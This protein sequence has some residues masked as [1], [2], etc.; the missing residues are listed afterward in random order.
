MSTFK[1]ILLACT[2]GAVVLLVVVCAERYLLRS[3]EDRGRKS[4]AAIQAAKDQI[5]IDSALARSRAVIQVALDSIERAKRSTA[6]HDAAQFADVV[7]RYRDRVV[8]DTVV[9]Q[10]VTAAAQQQR[11]CSE[12][13]EAC[14]VAR[15]FAERDAAAARLLVHDRDT[16]ILRL[17]HQAVPPPRSCVPQS[18]AGALLGAAAATVLH[19]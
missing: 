6:A 1:R 12:D 3:A 10:I 13:A 9:Q 5:A 18:L 7:V 4:G 11:S 15:E 8:H 16:T 17:A 19:R 14:R 2:A